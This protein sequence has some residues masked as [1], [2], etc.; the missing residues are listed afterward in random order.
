LW[1]IA[2]IISPDSTVQEWNHGTEIPGRNIKID[3]TGKGNQYF[4]LADRS[5]REGQQL[6]GDPLRNKCE[7]GNT[8]Y[9]R[10]EPV[11]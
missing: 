11:Q 3:A 8:D 10:A 6:H 1:L 9:H 2:S 4:V 5:E 7:T